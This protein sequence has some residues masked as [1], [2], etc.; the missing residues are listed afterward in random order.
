[1]SAADTSHGGTGGAEL[2]GEHGHPGT[3]SLYA[4]MLPLVEA[5]AT[6]QQAA[7]RFGADADEVDEIAEGFLRWREDESASMTGGGDDAALVAA[8]ERIAALEDENR[9]LR[10]RLEDLRGLIRRA[11]DV[12]ESGG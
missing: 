5:G 12:L 9:A 6:I 2:A 10:R 11:G 1:M 8:H 7:R 3:P 4:E